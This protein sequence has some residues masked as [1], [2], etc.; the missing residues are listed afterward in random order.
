MQ[1]YLDSV[2]AKM[3][4]YEGIV[5]RS[6]SFDNDELLKFAYEHKVGSIVTYQ[7]YT[8]TS[9]NISFYHENP[10]VI[11][12]IYSKNGRDIRKYNPE[13]NEVLYEKNMQFLVKHAYFKEGIYFLE[14]EE[15]PC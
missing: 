1:K 11:M 4:K 14:M 8:S 7:A 6:L 10:T 13:E 5:Y 12:K 15:M 3:P 9:T 2:L